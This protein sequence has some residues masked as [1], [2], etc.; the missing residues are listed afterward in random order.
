MGLENPANLG[1]LPANWG[2]SSGSGSLP[3]TQNPIVSSVRKMKKKVIPDRF[4]LAQNYPNP[5]RHSTTIR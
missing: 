1:Y 5:F 2:V 4:Y 3:G